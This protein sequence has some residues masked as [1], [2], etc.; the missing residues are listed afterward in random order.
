M[1]DLPLWSFPGVAVFALA[2]TESLHLL[3]PE[4]DVASPGTKPIQVSFIPYYIVIG[5]M[6]PPGRASPER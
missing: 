5:V 4:A 2:I 6:K 3:V 1:R